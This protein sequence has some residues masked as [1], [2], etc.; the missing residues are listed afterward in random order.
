M[1]AP[2]KKS[3]TSIGR[4]AELLQTAPG[5]IRTALDALEIG[6]ALELNDVPYYTPDQIDRIARRLAGT[7]RRPSSQPD[8]SKL[9]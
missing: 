4:V 5:R 7:T 6:A 9:D 1:V 2:A 8:P 3:L